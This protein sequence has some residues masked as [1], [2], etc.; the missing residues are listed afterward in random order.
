MREEK[1]HDKVRS[2]FKCRFTECG[3]KKPAD[4]AYLTDNATVR[5]LRCEEHRIKIGTQEQRYS[6][7]PVMR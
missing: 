6:K 7:R 2:F 4:Y 1:L 5:T 3:C